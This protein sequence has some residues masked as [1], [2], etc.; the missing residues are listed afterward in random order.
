MLLSGIHRG[1]KLVVFL[2]FVT[3]M[4]RLI[5]LMKFLTKYPSCIL[6]NGSP[7]QHLFRTNWQ[8]TGRQQTTTSNTFNQSSSCLFPHKPKLNCQALCK[9]KA[10]LK[11]QVQNITAQIDMTVYSVA[12]V[13]SNPTIVGLSLLTDSALKTLDKMAVDD[14]IQISVTLCIS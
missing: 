5:L 10:E 14:H 8:S 12:H 3:Y 11:K 6:E 9:V 2:L 4:Q 7:Q 13:I 1:T